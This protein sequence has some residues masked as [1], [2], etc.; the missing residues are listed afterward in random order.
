VIEVE[1]AV[2]VVDVAT[3]EGVVAVED[4]GIAVDGQGEDRGVHVVALEVTRAE[5]DQLVRLFR[6]E[7]D[8]HACYD[9][10]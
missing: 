3:L 2:H 7:Y 5:F 8:D 4:E 1:A 6:L 9:L 10:M